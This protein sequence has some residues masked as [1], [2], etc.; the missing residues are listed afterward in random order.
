MRIVVLRTDRLGELLLT[1]PLAQAL[2]QAHP[3]AH[4]T[5]VVQERYAELVRLAP[6]VDRV[7][8]VPWWGRRVRWRDARALIRQLRRE[9]FELA[10]VANPHK[11]LH[12]AVWRAHIPRR[13]GYDRKWAWCLTDRVPDIKASALRHEIEWNVALAKPLGVT[14]IRPQ[15]A[16]PVDDAAQRAIRE[17]LTAMGVAW[18][19]PVIALHPWASTV[20]KRWPAAFFQRAARALAAE[21][22]ATIIVIGGDEHAAEAAEFCRP[23]T[24]I[25]L[26][27]QLTLVEL[28]ACLRQCALLISNDS[29]PA[30]LAAAVG[31]PTITLFGSA[32]AAQGPIRWRP[33]GDGHIVLHQTPIDRIAVDDVLAAAQQRSHAW[34]R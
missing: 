15:L 23:V 7:L 29:G 33:W 22:G 31:T 1:L 32:H 2:R 12:W 10:L 20:E 3:D 21:Y 8:G 9:Q 5:F 17:R 28:A 34:T 6:G 18:H 16:L 19:A 4:I 25:N 27:G 14:A 13:I 24:A 30:H 26:T 11:W